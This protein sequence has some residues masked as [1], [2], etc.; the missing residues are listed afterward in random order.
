MHHSDQGTLFTSIALGMRCRRAG[1]RPSTVPQSE[2]CS[3]SATCESFFATL[4]FELLDRR[5]FRTQAEAHMFG[6]RAHRGP[7]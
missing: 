4:E 6:V 2:I 7:E 3:D 5:H 1:V